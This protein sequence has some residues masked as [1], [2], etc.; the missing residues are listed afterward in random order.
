MVDD[1]EK[2]WIGVEYFCNEPDPFWQSDDESIKEIAIKEM[3]MIGLLRKEEVLDSLVVKVEKAYPSYYGAYDRF[4]LVR[5]SLDRIEN[6]YLIGR[7]GM[8]RY[9]N[10]DHSMLTAMTAVKN[11]LTGRND[12]SNIWDINIGDEY[13]EEID[14]E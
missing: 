13:H 14:G 3:E 2:G 12:K 6:L 10:S 7:N 1:P 5:E 4:G 11:I 8:H 9:N